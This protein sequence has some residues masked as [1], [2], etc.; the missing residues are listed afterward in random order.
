[1]VLFW[2]LL[3]DRPVLVP[4]RPQRALPSLLAERGVD[5]SETGPFV[6]GAGE[7]DAGNQS[8]DEG[9]LSRTELYILFVHN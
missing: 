8:S 9:L 6:F 1:M 5:V 7:E 4:L 2:G 3:A